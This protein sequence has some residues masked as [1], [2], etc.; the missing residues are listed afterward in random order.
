MKEEVWP[1]ISVCVAN[2]NGRDVIDACLQSVYA[3]QGGIA[4]E[5]LV[6]DDA[7]TDGYHEEI[8]R[9]YPQVR[10][11]E[12]ETNVGFCIANNR[13][14]ARAR[15]QYL[16]LLNNDA[17]L[18]PDALESLLA[19]ASRLDKP[20]V[21]GLP[22]FDALTGELV[23]RGCMLDPFFNPVPNLDPR[24]QDVG[25]VIGACL[26][27]PASLWSEIGGFPSWFGSIAEDMYLCGRARLAGYPVRVP[28]CSGY[29]HWQGR[30]FGGNRITGGRLSTTY[31]RRALS[32]RNKTYV[33]FILTP[34]PL[35][36]FLLPLHLLTLYAEGLAVAVLKRDVDIWRCIYAPVLPALWHVRGQL[37]E[38]RK[39]S[40]SHRSASLAA[41]LAGFVVT[42]YKIRM[43][44]RHG[45]PRV[46]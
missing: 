37:T 22:Q 12:S 4:V 8:R 29:R 43:L 42:P 38:L 26:W 23:D 2:Y 6:H 36:Y 34:A 24:R 39:K 19:E 3:Q 14:A 13:M 40:Q 5:V 7:S 27:L 41:W 33:L 46:E 31:R 20:A 17:T 18:H 44:A 15:G 45:M 11:L 16:L 25:M 21:L 1:L 32:E 35:L 9:N 28:D 30:S 10:L